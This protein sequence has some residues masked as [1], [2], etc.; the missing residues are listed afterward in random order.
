MQ[1]PGCKANGAGNQLGAWQYS[2]LL[3]IVYMKKE[4]ESVLYLL[5]FYLVVF[6]S[7]VHVSEN[8]IK[9]NVLSF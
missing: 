8:D 3:A 5:F 7:L 6:F 4:K 9:I 1:W 2:D